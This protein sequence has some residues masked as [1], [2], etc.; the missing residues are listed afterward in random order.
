MKARADSR[1]KL[2]TVALCSDDRRDG[3][4]VSCVRPSHELLHRDEEDDGALS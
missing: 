4:N 1:Q 2:L 3:L